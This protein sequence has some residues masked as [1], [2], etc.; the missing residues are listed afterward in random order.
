MIGDEHRQSEIQEVRERDKGRE[1]GRD[2]VRT[3]RVRCSNK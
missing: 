3:E 2:V 1:L